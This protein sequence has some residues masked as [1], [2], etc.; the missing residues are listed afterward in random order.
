MFMAGTTGLEPATSAVTG[1][2]SN[3]LSYV[4]RLSCNNLS[5]CHI[6]RAVSLSSRLTLRSTLSL[7]W[8]QFRVAC[9]SKGKPE[10]PTSRQERVYQMRRGRCDQLACRL[11]KY[12]LLGPDFP[13]L[14]SEWSVLSSAKNGSRAFAANMRHAICLRQ[15][16]IAYCNRCVEPG[17]L[18][19]ASL[20]TRS[21]LAIFIRFRM[22]REPVAVQVAREQTVCWA[23]L[24][25]LSRRMR[26]TGK[27]NSTAGSMHG[28]RAW[29]GSYA[30]QHPRNRTCDT[31]HLGWAMRGGTAKRSQLQLPAK[32]ACRGQEARDARPPSTVVR[33]I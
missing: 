19:K 8:T 28:K 2:R 29:A 15:R 10:P 4:P 22:N 26:Y 33:L 21:L 30:A 23:G 7:L 18:S 14:Q 11:A 9:V 1:Q 31:L 32:A 20:T 3:Q 13:P 25:G 16:P 12:S 6:E 17:D 27:S 24:L 5:E